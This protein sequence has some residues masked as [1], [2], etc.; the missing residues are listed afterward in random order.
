M[1]DV[2]KIHFQKNILLS[3]SEE[4]EQRAPEALLRFSL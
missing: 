3:L 1:H 2:W 4:A